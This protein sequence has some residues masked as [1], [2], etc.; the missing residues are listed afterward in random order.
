MAD[1]EI[2]KMNKLKKPSSLIILF[3]IFIVICLIIFTVASLYPQSK[4]EFSYTVKIFNAGEEVYTI[5][6]PLPIF[7]QNESASYDEIVKCFQKESNSIEVKVV[8]TEHGK[9]LEIKSNDESNDDTIELQCVLKNINQINDLTLS[10]RPLEIENIPNQANDPFLFLYNDYWL[11]SDN[12]NIKVY[13]EEQ[14]EYLGKG[15]QQGTSASIFAN[16]ITNIGWEEYTGNIQI[17]NYE[18]N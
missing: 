14:Y 16:P 13:V 7:S 10:D 3:T 15:A 1:L 9:G 6:V 4:Y 11:Y 5:I 8:D 18:F 17:Y 2:S 12:D